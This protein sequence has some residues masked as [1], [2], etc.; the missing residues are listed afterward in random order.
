[1]SANIPTHYAQQFATNIELLL[2]QKGSR[3]RGAVMEGRHEGKQASPVDQYEAVEVYDV[4][5]RFA[6][7]TRVDAGTDRRWVRPTPSELPQLIDNF[8]LLKTITDPKSKYVENGAAAFGRRIDNHI[9]DAFFGTAYTGEDGSTSTTHPAAQQV[10][11][12]HGAGSDV[13]MTVK[14]LRE[15]RRLLKAA[16]V[17]LDM[18]SLHCALTARQEDNLLGETQIISIDYNARPV[19]VD[20]KLRSFLGYMFHHTELLDTDG[21]DDERIPCWVKSGMHLGVWGDIETNVSIRN[22]LSSQ[23]YQVYQKMTMGATRI[24]EE[25][26]V[27]VICDPN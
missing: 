18:E 15:A 6:P 24:E 17:D 27:E 14:K 11:V 8:D 26:V 16:N 9:I 2:Q 1:M 3:L 25:K 12:N 23:P 7:L 5:S 20:G 19:L 21:N 10:A 22:D 4:A 13:G